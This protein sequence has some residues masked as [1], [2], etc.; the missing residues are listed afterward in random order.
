MMKVLKESCGIVRKQQGRNGE[1]VLVVENILTLPF[2]LPCFFFFEKEM[3]LNHKMGI[4]AP[5]FV[6]SLVRP[7][8]VPRWTC[9]SPPPPLCAKVRI[10]TME[11]CSNPGCDQPGT[12]KCSGCKTTPYCGPTCQKAHWIV[13]KESC[14]GHCRKMGMAHLDKA[15]GFHREHNWSQTLRYSDLA[16]TKLKQLKDRPIED[17]S[18]ALSLKYNA[19]DYLGR[20]GEQLDCAKEWYCLWNTKPTDKGA[21]DAAFA[22]I[23]SCLQNKEYGD[24]HLYASTLYEI[25]NHKHDNKIPDD[26]R[27]RYIADGAYCLAQ[28]TFRFAKAGGIPPEE[29]QKAGQEAIVLARRALEIHTQLYGPENCEVANDMGVLAEALDYFND[30]DNEEV[31]CLLE[32][33]KAIH[34]RVYG[35]S[36]T[37]VAIGEQKLGEVYLYQAKRA[38]AADDLDRCVA[39]MELALPHYRESARIYRAIGRMDDADG[40]AQIAVDIE[41]LLR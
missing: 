19:L 8:L 18:E 2:G 11:T 14:D 28:A 20:Y 41:E 7:R 4:P 35:S 16:A 26:Q 25:I 12:N 23:Q 39:S 15:R 38:R 5:F 34:A 22:L 40:A 29:K 37:N 10:P 1:A 33:S 27:Q 13:H 3:A 6:V 21:I 32:Q 9:P 17:L 30:D 31:L 36:S 24:A